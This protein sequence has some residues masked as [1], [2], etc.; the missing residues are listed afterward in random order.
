M[1]RE[2][3]FVKCLHGRAGR[4][5]HT[6]LT[7]KALLA[8]EEFCQTER[9]DAVLVLG[10]VNSTLACSIV[11]KKLNIP[12]ARIEAGPRSGDKSMP[13]KINSLGSRQYFRQFFVLSQV[14]LHT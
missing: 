14:A 4:G 1:V 9:L 6:Q 13:G 8:F 5:S 3:V 7:S 2:P 10:D 11:V 12:V